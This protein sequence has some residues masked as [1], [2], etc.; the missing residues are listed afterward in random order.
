MGVSTEDV[1]LL[2]ILTSGFSTLLN[3]T[4]GLASLVSLNTGAY[5]TLA[6]DNMV[7]SGATAPTVATITSTSVDV[8]G[9]SR[10]TVYY[11][12]TGATT[13]VLLTFRGGN[14][15][16][17]MYT[18]RSVTASAGLQA[19]VVGDLTTGAGAET[20]SISRIDDILVQ[21]NLSANTGASTGVTTT[22]RTRFLTQP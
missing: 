13:G 7:L 5:K 12:V 15:G 20:N 9:A 17:G 2:H 8:R 16:F 19:F 1:R 14:S 21:A 4:S 18:L 6:V 10:V 3:H 22:I 11:D